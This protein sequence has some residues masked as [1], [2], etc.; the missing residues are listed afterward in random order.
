MTANPDHLLWPNEV[1]AY[2]G[3]KQRT[4]SQALWATR[5]HISQEGRARPTDLPLPAE[6]HIRRQVP[7]RPPRRIGHG[8]RARDRPKSSQVTRTVYQSRWRRGDL[9]A[10]LAA[11]RSA[12]A[13]RIAARRDPAT[14]RTATQRRAS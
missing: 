11:L 3:V 10:Y 4:V 2:L 8:P 13:A 7:A 9:D 1:A 12:R 5:K 14:G 6:E